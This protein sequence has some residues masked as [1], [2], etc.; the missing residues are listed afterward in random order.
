MTPKFRIAAIT[1]EF[2]PDLSVALQAM[3][4]IGMTGAELRV[5]GGKNI[6]DLTAD[7]L[8]RIVDTNWD[9]PVTA[10]ARLVSIIDDSAQHLGQAAYLQ[11]IA[12]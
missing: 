12:Q 7:E 1:D 6:M 4:P 11:G 9:P 5:V 8:S 3:K 2:S 10:S